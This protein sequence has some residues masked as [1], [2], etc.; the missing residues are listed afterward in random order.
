MTRIAGWLTLCL[1]GAGCIDPVTEPRPTITFFGSDAAVVTSG[2]NHRGTPVQATLR[3]DWQTR[4]ADDVTLRFEAAVVPLTGCRALVDGSNC[5]RD[6]SLELEPTETGTYTL[7]ALRGAGSCMRD[8]EGQLQRPLECDEA[9]VLV[10]VVPPALATLEADRTRVALGGFAVLTY[11][12]QSTAGWRLGSVELDGSDEVLV[13]CLSEVEAAG[14]DP[15]PMCLLPVGPD[16]LAKT[17]AQVTVGPLQQTTPFSLVAI[18]GAQ[19][20]LGRIGLGEVSVTID[21]N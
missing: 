20:D 14:V 18:N 9:E 13:P 2:V 10:A 7:Q 1:C 12:V 21:V 19:D 4:L 11:S 3:L 6:A 5:V 15:P 8:E 16:G 17:D